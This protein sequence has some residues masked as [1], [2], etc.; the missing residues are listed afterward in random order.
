MPDAD[1]GQLDRLLTRLVD[2][3]IT[4]EEFAALEGQLDGDAHAQERYLH[5]LGLHA[6]L[7]ET[8]VTPE[9]W[10]A[11]GRG[12]SVNV[13]RRRR[14]T[15][16]LLGAAAALIL[17]G[18]SG[19]P[20]PAGARCRFRIDRTYCRVERSSSLDRGWRSADPWPQGW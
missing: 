5:Y 9:S 10:T 6:D 7:L 14:T 19:G 20:F 11:Q 18:V 15:A 4:V 2:K 8:G 12:N 3:T 13:D 16:W 1:H 17:L